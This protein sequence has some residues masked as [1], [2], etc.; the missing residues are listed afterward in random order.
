MKKSRRWAS[1]GSAGGLEGRLTSTSSACRM[2]TCAAPDRPGGSAGEYHA[3]S[4][5]AWLRSSRMCSGIASNASICLSSIHTGM[6]RSRWATSPAGG[7][8][9]SVSAGVQDRNTPPGW[10]ATAPDGGDGD[11]STVTTCTTATKASGERPGRPRPA[12]PRSSPDAAGSAPA[13][14]AVAPHP[15][16]RS[17]A[18]CAS[19]PPPPGL[20]LL[21]QWMPASQ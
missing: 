10:A 15:A 8:F 1:A 21:Q 20:P 6:L 12:G 4:T 2:R 13:R 14:R 16:K 5:R 3:S 9:R 18:P 17:R 7:R 11:G 19:G